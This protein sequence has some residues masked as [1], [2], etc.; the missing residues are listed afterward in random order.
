MEERYRK[1]LKCLLE[2]EDL[3]YNQL[4]QIAGITQDDLD[5]IFKFRNTKSGH[6]VYR[7]TYWDNRG[8]F[9]NAAWPAVYIVADSAHEAKQMFLDGLRSNFDDFAYDFNPKPCARKQLLADFD[10]RDK[11]VYF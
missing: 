3:D 10:E 5:A 6:K 8:N 7:G 9:K 2:S 4:V 11:G 1:L